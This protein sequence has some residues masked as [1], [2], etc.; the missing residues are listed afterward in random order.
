MMLACTKFCLNIC[1][2]FGKRRLAV[3][4]TGKSDTPI[5]EFNLFQVK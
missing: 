1:F 4:P 3:G 2:R 5:I